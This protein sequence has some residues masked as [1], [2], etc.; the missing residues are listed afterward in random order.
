MLLVDVATGRPRSVAG[1]VIDAAASGRPPEAGSEGGVEGELQRYMVE[2][3][4]SACT[5]LAD[6]ERELR[7]WRHRVAVA[8]REAGAGSAA[9]GTAPLAG[10]GL[11]TP[12][13]RYLRMME[14]FGPVVHDV[15]TCGSHVH[16][17]VES[18]EDGV[19]VIDRIRVWLPVVLALSANSPFSNGQDTGYASY[20]S[21]LW[22]RWPSAGPSDLF[23]SAAAYH[24]VVRSM[25]ESG[26]L[27]DDGMI[28]FDAR[29]SHRYPTV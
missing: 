24:S 25:V 1:R 10:D 28:Y 5:E 12:K 20:R 15:L 29:L 11:I 17:S 6:V 4:S 2:T 16:V 9:L 23:G 8:A 18:D 14:R 21:Q 22:L 7:G 27:L 13:P 19:A 3:Q 26:V